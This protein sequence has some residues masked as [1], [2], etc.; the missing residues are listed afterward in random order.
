MSEVGS[1]LWQGY[2]PA[3]GN[4]GHGGGLPFPGFDDTNGQDGSFKPDAPELGPTFPVEG[5]DEDEGEGEGYPDYPEDDE[6]PEE[7][8]PEEPNW[9]GEKD[10]DEPDEHEL[11]PPKVDDGSKCHK[12]DWWGS[13]P[14]VS[15]NLGNWLIP[16][17]S[18][19]GHPDGISYNGDIFS[20]CAGRTQECTDEM[21]INWEGY[22]VESDLAYISEHGA[23][24]VRIPVPFYA[25]IDTEGDE[26]YPVSEA[27]KEELT[28]VLNLLPD[29]DLHAV[30]DIHA[31]PGTIILKDYTPR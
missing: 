19:M 3:L 17:W 14:A 7:P 2:N 20:Q 6:E 25:F 26:P 10:G 9:D 5:G 21:R 15:V 1:Q 18:W 23:N 16:E 29:Y 4:G 8:R 30:I 27:Q 24:M 31:V 12:W 22:I 28:R 11:Q 13:K